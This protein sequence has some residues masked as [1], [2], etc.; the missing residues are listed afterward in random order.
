MVCSWHDT[1][2]VRNS[3][4]LCGYRST[5]CTNGGSGGGGA[6]ATAATAA[7]ACPA[8]RAG[9]ATAPAQRRR[10]RAGRRRAGRR[11][12]ARHHDG[13][14]HVTVVLRAGEAV[15]AARRQGERDRGGPARMRTVQHRRRLGREAVRPG[16]EVRA[17]ALRAEHV[18]ARAPVGE[19]E[20]VGGVHVQRAAAGHIPGDGIG[21]LDAVR[22]LQAPPLLKRARW[23]RQRRGLVWRFAVSA[24]ARPP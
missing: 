6:A 2:Y 17:R 13:E 20:R 11:I 19:L 16:Q 15:G 24:D 1:R 5:V 10:R 22:G 21:P 14:V 8:A 3:Y 18:M 12:A 7:V 4:S 23:G 9:A